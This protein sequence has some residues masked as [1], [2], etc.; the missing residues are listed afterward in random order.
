MDEF[1]SKYKYMTMLLMELRAKLAEL[2]RQLTEAKAELQ[3]YRERGAHLKCGMNE[4]KMIEEEI[5]A[6]ERQI[7]DVEVR[8]TMLQPRGDESLH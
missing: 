4:T 7:H 5:A 6:F 2:N 8:L 1:L 3:F